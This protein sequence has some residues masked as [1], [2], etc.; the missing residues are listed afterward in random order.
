MVQ[1]LKEMYNADSSKYIDIQVS[2]NREN[3]FEQEQI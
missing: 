2:Y 3:N 1:N